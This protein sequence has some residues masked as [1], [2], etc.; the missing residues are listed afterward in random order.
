M[1]ILFMRN[2]WNIEN[3]KSIAIMG[4][5]FDPIHYGHLVAAEAVRQEL[6]VEK[7]IFIPSG[8]P[9]HK[10]NKQIANNEHRYLMTVL[11]TVDNP[12]FEASRIEIDRPG[13][14]Y[15]V[16]TIR[17]IRQNCSE[18]CKIYFITGADATA[19]ILNW[20]N[21]EELFSMCEFVAVTRPGYDKTKAETEK[22]FEGKIKYLEVPALSISSTDIRNRVLADKSIK[23]LVP[24]SVEE[25]IRKFSLY[26]GSP[27]EPVIDMINKKL[28]YMLSPK[29]FE[30]TQG[31]ANESVKLAKKH[32]A[33]ERKA[34]IAGLL[35]DC[36]KDYSGKDKLRMCEKLGIELDSIMIN[37]SDLTHSFLGAVLA[38]DMF[39][40]EDEDILNAVKY[41][42]TGRA[43]MSDLEKIVYLAD[44]FE[45]SRTYFDGMDEMKRLAYENL[46]KAVAFS[47]EHTINYNKKKNR[48]IHPLS[49]EALEYYTK[50]VNKEDK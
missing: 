22:K 36:A 19:E 47:L 7:V 13:T 11:A 1:E 49:M 35:H 21:P 24:E 50:S 25:Y 42:T 15:T 3:C 32:G 18:A 8:R 43:G 16:D 2:I 23:Y 12:Y 20:K 37:Q 38:K 40:I 48:L 34:Y 45:P 9:P 26:T 6:D 4:G 44:F 14:T 5:T 31:V 29:R 41:H 27:D 39:G 28:H 30:H 33:D 17:E 10:K 46:D